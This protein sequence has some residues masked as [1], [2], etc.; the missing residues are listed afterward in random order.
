MCSNPR[1]NSGRTERV[2]TTPNLAHHCQIGLLGDPLK[3]LDPVLKRGRVPALRCEPV[4]HRHDD[5]VAELGHPPAEGV[6]GGGAAAPGGEPAAVE[7]H[8]DGQPPA[9]RRRRARRG[10]GVREVPAVRRGAVGRGGR[11]G[12][13]GAARVGEEVRVG[14]RRGEEDADGER[15]VG[16][17]VEVL[18]GDPVG[19]GE[20]RVGGRG[21]LVG[22]A[23]DPEGGRGG[24][25][26]APGGGKR[27]EAVA[28][29]ELEE[30]AVDLHADARHGSPSAGSAHHTG[31]SS[32][33]IR[34]EP[35][36]PRAPPPDSVG[37]RGIG[38]D[39][40]G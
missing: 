5:G 6:V 10:D 23:G 11:G 16:V 12:V 2:H 21:G 3:N 24:V 26:A 28:E 18:G 14:R 1:L 29:P 36:L 39:W 38:S 20:G 32:G 34:S 13:A 7:L 25:G 4:S 19:G 35:S 22:A 30:D 8:D 40:V 9:R 33:G 17:D 27:L 37:L 31:R 15:G